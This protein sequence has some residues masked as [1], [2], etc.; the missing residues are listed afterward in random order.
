MK[1]VSRSVRTDKT[2]NSNDSVNKVFL[3][4][5]IK[6]DDLKNTVTILNRKVKASITFL[7]K[8]E[9]QHG[10]GEVTHFIDPA[11]N[12][13]EL[14]DKE[15]AELEENRISDTMLNIMRKKAERH[16][17]RKQTLQQYHR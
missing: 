17:L 16:C 13:V 9:Y 12:L 8:V 7:E 2:G 10:I 3:G 15:S 5:G 14:L 1:T 4:I 11:G 6:V